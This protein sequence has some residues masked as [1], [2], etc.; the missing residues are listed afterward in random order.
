MI[1]TKNPKVLKN[2]LAQEFQEFIYKDFVRK[3]TVLLFKVANNCKKP[4]FL[5]TGHLVKVEGSL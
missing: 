5:H 1:H 4:K 3:F 2:P